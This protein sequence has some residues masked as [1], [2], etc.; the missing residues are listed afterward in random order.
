MSRKLPDQAIAAAL[1]TPL[2]Q[3]KP[4]REAGDSKSDS[5]KPQKANKHLTYVGKPPARRD[6][7]QHP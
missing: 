1:P 2:G 6:H 7:G 3:T 4:P 5:H